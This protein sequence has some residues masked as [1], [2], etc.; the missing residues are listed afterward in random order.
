MTNNTGELSALYWALH[1]ARARRP[2]VGKEVIHSD[3]LYAINMA[4]GKWMPKVKRNAAMIGRV[5]ALWYKLQAARP[6]EVTL[7][8]VRSHVKVP[9]NEIADWLAG[10]GARTGRTTLAQAERWMEQWLRR[11]RNLPGE[12]SARPPGG[13]AEEE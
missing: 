9:G 11:Q 10:R 3:S 8:H 13:G 1:R 6:G 7:R 4:T 5:R 2:R 12:S